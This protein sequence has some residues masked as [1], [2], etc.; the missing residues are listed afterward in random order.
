M[1]ATG[2]ETGYLAAEKLRPEFAAALKGLQAGETAGPVETPEAF[3]LIRICGS[4]PA[5][6][7]PF[8]K[9]RDRIEQELMDRALAENR[10]R[11]EE[12]LREKAV[13]RYFGP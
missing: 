3:Y 13:I 4:R 5:K 8:A 10:R 9:I 11:Y 6:K 2:G 1:A 12:K 7:I